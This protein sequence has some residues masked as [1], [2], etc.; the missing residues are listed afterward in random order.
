[1]GYCE[2][3]Q[4]RLGADGERTLR[5][6][7]CRADTRRSRVRRRLRRRRPTSRPRPRASLPRCPARLRRTTRGG[8]LACDLHRT[9]RHRRRA[10]ARAGGRRRRAGLPDKP[11]WSR[12]YLQR[13]VARRKQPNKQA[14][15]QANKQTIQPQ[16]GASA[17]AARGLAPHGSARPFRS[18]VCLFVCAAR[19]GA[20]CSYSK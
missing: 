4:A 9:V 15:K 18:F 1:M 8:A 10:R 20:P 13:A 2:Y 19:F 5:R 14:N 17:A 12:M 16:P 7:P 11:A 6:G 3:S